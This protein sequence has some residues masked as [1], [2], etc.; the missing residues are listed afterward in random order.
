MATWTFITL[1]GR[2]QRVYVDQ[3]K[4]MDFR[5]ALKA[6]KAE[7]RI[8][9]MTAASIETM[10]NADPPDEVETEFTWRWNS[11]VWTFLCDFEMDDYKH[12]RHDL[13]TPSV[14]AIKTDVNPYTQRELLD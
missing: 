11:G 3:V 6:W 13:D 5:S 7:V 9:G 1:V 12:D 2:E 14:W 8:E 4:A 10:A